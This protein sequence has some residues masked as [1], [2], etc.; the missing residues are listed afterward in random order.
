MSER[1]V[2]VDVQALQSVAHAERGIGRTVAD[3]TSFLIN[4]GAPIAACTMNPLLPAPR[5]IPPAIANSGNLVWG[6]ASALKDIA[7]SG[8]FIYHVMSPY[9]DVRPSDAL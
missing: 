3:H 9:E 5:L 1:R 6:T 8:P 7:A 2:V 4:A